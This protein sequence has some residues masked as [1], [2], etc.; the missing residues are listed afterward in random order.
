MKKTVLLIVLCIMTFYTY[1]QEKKTYWNNGNLK[2]KTN[3][4]KDGKRTGEW[5]LYYETGELKEYGSYE[6]GKK[7]GR[8][9]E[10]YYNGERKKRTYYRNGLI[11][12]KSTYYEN[13]RMMIT[14]DFDNNEKKH[15]IWEQNYDNW[16]QKIK[17]EYHHGKKDGQWKY[18][19]DSGKLHKVENYKV[20]KRTSKWE[21]DFEDNNYSDNVKDAVD[22]S[23]YT[24][25]EVVEEAAETTADIEVEDAAVDVAKEASDTA[26]DAVDAV[27]GAVDAATEVVEDVD[28]ESIE[29]AVDASSYYGNR[30]NGEWKF[31]N[32]NGKCIEIGN[33]IDDKKDG[34]WT[35]YYD[36]GELKKVQL[37]KEDK[38]MEVVSYVDTKG[39]AYDKGTLKYGSGT[40]KEYN[41]NSEL[42]S[43]IEYIYGEKLDWNDSNQ[44]NNLAWDVYENETDVKVLKTAIK[45][46]ERSIELD[47]NYYNT[48]TYAALLY[49][50]GKYKQA[51]NFAEQAVK[52]AK[53]N[54][55]DY[56]STTKL[57]E[58]IY[59]K[60]KKY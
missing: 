28:V 34:K 10:Y 4:D 16:Q 30:L 31:Y 8:W 2:S 36:N 44:L 27:K 33:Y 48:D 35:Y 15:G 51:L 37:W 54:D 19:T 1:A 9:N 58:Q 26:K 43:T 52:I 56:S 32:E 57:I 17:G 39:K 55:D 42:I 20:G 11:T 53:K 29:V 14:G 45:W 38:L 5:N 18:Y 24:V 23:K 41:D 13:G 47:K 3:H 22:A 50:T 25:E 7:I 46:V 21:G 6:D 59:I 12:E 60:M 40:V 49:K